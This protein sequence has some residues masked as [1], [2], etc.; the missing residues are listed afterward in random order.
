MTL[1]W[2]LIAYVACGVAASGMLGAL[3]ALSLT[4]TARRGQTASTVVAGVL[5]LLACAAGVARLGRPEVAFHVLTRMNSG[6]AQGYYAVLALL[7][8]A[9]IALVVLRRSEGARQTLPTWAGVV[10][11]VVGAF[12]CYGIAAN[13]TA[14]SLSVAKTL[15]VFAYL[16]ACAFCLG[17]LVVGSLQGAPDGEA[18]ASRGS[19]AAGAIA[20]VLA[21]ASGVLAVVVA[22]F[23]PRMGG[24]S[25][26]V[27]TSPYGMVS[28]HATD[29]IASATGGTVLA[30]GHA[31]LFWA[32]A[33]V[34]GALVPLVC[35]LVV[36]RARGAAGV[37]SA[38]VGALCVVVGACA[39]VALVLFASS[40]TSLL[41]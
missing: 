33:V 17:L 22:V 40:V 35:A 20:A 6:I 9:I 19:G 18:E 37:V 3:G 8:V 7:V 21:A 34:V 1:T 39:T 5:A 2:A 31:G 14:T 29:S 26:S 15:L 38:V 24:H 11:L 30:S 36:R 25:G 41:N 28:A 10:S 16:L 32:L 12:G 13:L 27:V 23:A 4:G